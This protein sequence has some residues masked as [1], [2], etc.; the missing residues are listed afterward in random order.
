MR[1]YYLKTSK[2]KS[3]KNKTT[4]QLMNKNNLSSKSVKNLHDFEILEFLIGLGFIFKEAL[5]LYYF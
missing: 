2:K 5:F 4:N 3:P 1:I